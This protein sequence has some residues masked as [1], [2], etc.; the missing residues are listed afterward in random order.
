MRYLQEIGIQSTYGAKLLNVF[1]SEALT[2]LQNDPLRLAK[3]LPR[4]GFQIADRIMQRSGVSADD[5]QRIHACI[6]HILQDFAE[7]GNTCIPEDTLHSRC[8]DQFGI[9]FEHIRQAIDHL[10]SEKEIIA[11]NGADD[12]AMSR[13]LY[14]PCFHQAETAIARRLRIMQA[15]PVDSPQMDATAMAQAVLKKLALKLSRDQLAV[16]NSVLAHRVAIITGGPGTGKT[17]LIRSLAAVLHQTG[18][19]VLL[20]APTGRAARRL[21]MLAHMEAVTIHKLLG[22]NPSRQLFDK[23]RDNPL[24]ADAIIV[25]EASMVDT[26]LMY[27]LINAVHITTRLIIVGDVYQL[28]SVGPGN[29]LSDL[30]RS[31][32][33]QTFELTEIF[34]QAEQSTIVVN[35]HQIRQGRMPDVVAASAGLNECDDFCFIEQH[36]PTAAVDA[37]VTLCTRHIAE[38]LGYDPLYEVQILTPMHKGVAGAVNL[39]RILQQRLNPNSV[40]ATVLGRPYKLN[41]KVMHLKN[42]YAKDVFNGDIGYVKAIDPLKKTVTIQYESRDIDYEFAEMG[43]VSLAYAISVHKSQ[44]SEYPV[45]ILPVLTQQYAMLYRSLMYTAITRAK[46]I[47]ILVGSPKALAIAVKNDQPRMR[48]TG[49]ADRID[50]P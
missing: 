14:L 26:M 32:A 10:A 38:R 43:E 15:H 22:F 50:S 12:L 34:R 37:M 19:K 2:V 48:L 24:D 4:I 33:F 40:A 5:P 36:R 13:M 16:L 29:V 1:G 9:G 28:P 49:L 25:D 39:N 3:E 44:G 35:A 31:H 11:E 8:T 7:N 17:T 45:V 30:I 21:T 20:A 46:N 41:D 27:Y 18:R 6:L 47:V 23:N 42:N